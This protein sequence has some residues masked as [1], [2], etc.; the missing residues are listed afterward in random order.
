MHS[1]SE[2]GSSLTFKSK[3]TI[4]ICSYCAPCYNQAVSAKNTSME[5]INNWRS[6]QKLGF[7][8]WFREYSWYSGLISNHKWSFDITYSVE[9]KQIESHYRDLFIELANACPSVL[10]VS[11]L[12]YFLRVGNGDVITPYQD[13]FVKLLNADSIF[14]DILPSQV[15]RSD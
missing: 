1:C 7:V 9:R 5:R 6:G 10:E 15:K 11:I 3:F 8:D 13:E 4:C 12:H 2:D 14:C